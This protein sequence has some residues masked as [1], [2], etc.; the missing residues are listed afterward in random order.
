MEYAGLY[1]T[2]LNYTRV[3]GIIQDNTKQCWIILSILVYTG[4]SSSVPDYTELYWTMMD[5]TW[6]YWT[7][8]DYNGMFW[9]NLESIYRLCISATIRQTLRQTDTHSDR[10]TQWLTGP[11][12]ERH[13]P[14]KMRFKIPWVKKLMVGGRILKEREEMVMYFTTITTITQGRTLK[15]GWQKRYCDVLL[16]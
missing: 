12:L 16:L 15:R 10:Q 13:A 2:I 14:L 9:Y 1:W 6:L 8:L 7:E 3:Y 5:Y 11:D 4:Q